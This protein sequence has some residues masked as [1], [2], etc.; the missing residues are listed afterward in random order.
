MSGSSARALSWLDV[1]SILEKL[2]PDVTREVVLVGGQALNFWQSQLADNAPELRAGPP[3]TS[4]DIDFCGGKDAVRLFAERLDGQALFASMDEAT[5]STGLVLFVDSKGERHKIDFIDQPYGL[6][7]AEVRAWAI[8]ARLVD[9]SGGPSP[10]S[11]L[12]MHPVHC[13]FSRVKNTMEFRL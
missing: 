12:V 13:V 1:Q 9:D 3:L 8:P 7:T 5:P 10:L 6:T 4:A 2:G 11:L